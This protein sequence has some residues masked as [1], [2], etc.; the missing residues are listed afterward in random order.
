MGALGSQP[1]LLRYLIGW[2][3]EAR[4]RGLT[5]NATA[6]SAESQDPPVDGDVVDPDAALG[7]QLLDVAVGEPEP[8][9]PADRHNDHIGWEAEAGERRP[10]CDP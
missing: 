3:A 4:P 10:R 8:E 1:G 6:N 7:Q 2:H 9:V 5:Y